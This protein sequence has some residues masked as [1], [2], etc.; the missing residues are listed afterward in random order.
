VQVKS[1]K[2]N[3][4]ELQVFSR[5][6]DAERSIEGEEY[7]DDKRDIERRDVEADENSENDE[8]NENQG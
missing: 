7:D 3:G 6:E 1:P 4:S 8:N 5:K 2:R